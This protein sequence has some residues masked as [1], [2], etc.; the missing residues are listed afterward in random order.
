MYEVRWHGRG[1]Q[2][3]VTAS[4]I[5]AY[6]A[7]KE[8]QYLQSFPD[9]GPE[10]M[11][12]PVKA[13]T[14]IDNKPIT[15]HSQVY[16]PDAVIVLDPTLLE[17]INVAEGLKRDGILIVNTNLSKEKIREI[18][19]FQG[20]IFVIN[21]TK[22]ALETIG[23]PLANVCGVAALSKISGIIQKENIIATIREVL[24]KKFSDKIIKGNIDA[25]NRA[26]IEVE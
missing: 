5:L 13:Y 21:A 1:G 26:Y 8:D 7:L 22:I 24:G 12:A 2:G 20:K 17:Q 9:F 4:E 14:R 25:V 16:E 11:G 15:I 3:V 6:A 18:T 10:R 19:K 23:K